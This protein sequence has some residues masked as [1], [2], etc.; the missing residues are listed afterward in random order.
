MASTAELHPLQTLYRNWEHEQWNPWSIDLETDARQ[1]QNGLSDP[2]KGLIYWALSSLMVGEE[3]ITTKFAALV[4]AAD[5][6]EEATF[7]S[8][9]QVDEARHMQFY[10]RFQDDVID[11]PAAIAAHV[12]RSREQLG[13]SFAL[14][15]DQAL[16][17]AHDRV[18][19]TPRD[20]VA[21]VEFVTTYH[22][23]IESMLGLT[24]FQFITRYLRDNQL[25]PGFVDGYS[26]I[27]HDEQRHIGYGVWY[28]REA[29]SRDPELGEQIRRTLRQLLPIAASALAPPRREGTDWEALGATSN[30]ITEF[31]VTALTRRLKII[32]VPLD[33]V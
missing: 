8:S 19:A 17:S 4:M 10:A 20:P 13:D 7:A 3:R 28:L 26:Q 27:H 24:A 11:E 29:A 15:F 30:E 25:L 16:V 18:V 14:I 5:T 6:E 9:Q 12:A 31:A 21:K 23:V 22:L 33:T 2:D 32:G 1:W